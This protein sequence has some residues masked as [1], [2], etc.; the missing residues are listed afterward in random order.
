MFLWSVIFIYVEIKFV[1]TGFCD[2]VHNGGLISPLLTADA[3]VLGA[4]DSGDIDF[5]LCKAGVYAEH[6]R[7][8][9]IKPL[10]KALLKS[11]Q[12]NAKLSWPVLAWN[13]NACCSTAPP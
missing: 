11:Q 9:M 13:Q 8:I 6:C 2:P 12:V 10:Q 7:D 4:V 5:S 1:C 3:P